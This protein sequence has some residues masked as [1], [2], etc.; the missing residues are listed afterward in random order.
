MMESDQMD[1]L[2]MA[3]SGFETVTLTMLS[4]LTKYTHWQVS[5]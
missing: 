4:G 3:Q 1:L 5:Q 2:A